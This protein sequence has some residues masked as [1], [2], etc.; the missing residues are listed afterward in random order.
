VITV[1]PPISTELQRIYALPRPPAVVLN[2]PVVDPAEGS[3]PSLRQVVGLPDSTPLVVYSGMMTTARGVHTAIEAMRSLPGVHLALVCVPH[4]ETWSVRKLRPLATQAGLDARVHFLDPVRP[5]EVVDFLRSADLGLLP[6]LHFPSHEM[7]LANKMFEYVNAGLPVVVSDCRTQAEFVRSHR[8]GEVFRA[9]DATGLADAVRRVLGD[10]ATYATAVQDPALL[11]QY[12]WRRQEEVLR[13]VYA[14]VLD[15]P[16]EWT[17][18]TADGMV[19][20]LRESPRSLATPA[21]ATP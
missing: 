17:G 12:S 13:G 8:I 3:R 2:A 5:G 10:R 20:D 1:S 15:R 9:G 14:E 7:A 6:F 19:M 11:E 18:G 4:T 16:V 21:P